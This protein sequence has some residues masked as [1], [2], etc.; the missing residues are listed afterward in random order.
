MNKTTSSRRK[1][2]FFARSMARAYQ[3]W[4]ERRTET[5]KKRGNRS[6][7]TRIKAEKRPLFAEALEPRVLFSGSPM[8]V[9]EPADSDQGGQ[10]A[11]A[12]SAAVLDDG[13]DAVSQFSFEG[14]ESED[15]DFSESD[16][17]RLAAEAIVRW[18][19]TGLSAGQLEALEQI[20]YVVTDLEGS[21]LAFAEGDSIYIDYNGAGAD[22][23]V[24]DT[25]WLDEEF[26]EI[27][28]ILRAI[29]GDDI[30]GLAGE[31]VDL[32]SVLMHE[33]GHI[34]GL[35]D[36]Y[37]SESE[38]SAMHGL[39]EEGERRVLAHAQA[40][41][42][43]P[44]APDL[45]H[46]AALKDGTGNWIGET[47]VG[48]NGDNWTTGANWSDGSAPTENPFP[49]VIFD[50]GNTNV[51][52][53]TGG[54]GGR[55]VNSIVFD[56]G[57]G[58]F[59]LSGN[60]IDLLGTSGVGDAAE[61]V[62]LSTNTQTINSQLILRPDLTSGTTINA[63]A[64]DIV[65]GG[66]IRQL[67][68]GNS[69]SITG[70]HIVT[71]SG[72]NTYSD[73]TLIGY[74]FVEDDFESY[75]VGVSGSDSVWNK[76]TT[77]RVA[78]AS[79]VDGNFLSFG[80]DGGL[81]SG[82][83]GGSTE[84]RGIHR[85]LEDASISVGSTG[86]VTFD[87]RTTDENGEWYYGLT[88]KI[89]GRVEDV[90]TAGAQPR[91]A[92]DMRAYVGLVSDGIVG[93]GKVNLVAAD[94]GTG[95]VTL[96]TGLNID[97][98]HQIELRIDHTANTYEVFLG[99]VQQGGTLNFAPATG[100]L[101]YF[102]AMGAG[103]SRT[104]TPFD[105]Q[106][107]NLQANA[108]TGSAT[109]L[110]NGTHTGAGSYAVG[111]ESTLGGT[112]SSDAEVSVFGTL[113]PGELS[114]IESL[115]VGGL[116][117]L[118]GSTFEVQIGG[119]GSMVA[120]SGND[121]VNVTGDVV[122]GSGVSTL[123]V[124]SLGTPATGA[125]AYTLI[126]IESGT[127]TGYFKDSSGTA[128]IEGATVTVGGIDY[129]ISYRGGDGNDVVLT[130][131]QVLYVNSDFVL[132]EIELDSENYAT[133]PA[134]TKAGEW[135]SS[136]TS[137]G[138][139]GNNYLAVANADTT[140]NTVEYAPELQGG[141]YD[142]SMRWVAASN[143][144]TN[145]T[146]TIVDGYGDSHVVSVN[147]EQNNNV[148]V[149]LGEY[150]FA[151]GNAGSVTISNE[152]ANEYVIAD[153]M[154]F[155][156]IL[157]VGSDAD[158]EVI[159]DQPGT[160]YNSIS[161][162]IAAAATDE[163]LTLI[164]NQ[165]DYSAEDIDLSSFTDT[166]TIKFIEGDSSIGS[167]TGGS[168]VTV[169]LGGIDGSHSVATTLSVGSGA[170]G[171]VI[172]GDGGLTKTGVGDFVLFGSLN[173][174]TGATQVL[175]GVLQVESGSI[176]ATDLILID[177]G[178]FQVINGGTVNVTN[179]VT[180]GAGAGSLLVDHG[181]MT[182][183]SG[184]DVDTLRTGLN[185]GTSQLTV[186]SGVV[187]V[188]NGTEDLHIGRTEVASNNT[189]GTVDFS[190]ASSV[191]ID[192][193]NLRLGTTLAAANPG[194]SRGSL[195]LS[196][197]GSN[198]V[199]ANSILIGDSPSA[200]NTS[201]PSTIVLGLDNIFNVD[202]FTIGGQKSHGRVTIAS[203][204]VFDLSGNVN[205]STDLNL[206]FNVTGNTG[207][208]S[209]GLLDL[210][211]GI[212]NATLDD[213]R[214]GRHDIGPGSG[215][216][217]ITFDAGTVTANTVALGTG[218]L[219]STGTINQRGGTFTV[220]N[221]VSE[222]R[223][224]TLNIEAGN[225]VV[226]AGGLEVDNLTVGYADLDDIGT[227][228]NTGILTVNGGA[229]SIGDGV[230]N[231]LRI[232]Y[233]TGAN[234]G[235]PIAIGGVNFTQADS[236]TINV[237][238]IFIGSL[239]AS[240][241]TGTRG[242]LELSNVGDNTITADRIIVGDS[243]SPGNQGVTSTLTFGSNMNTV[244]VDTFDV[245][246]RKS[247][248]TV[249]IVSGGTLDLSGNLNA[250]NETDLR[251]GINDSANTGT[252]TTGVFDM[253]NGVFNAT[254]D[255]IILGRHASSSGGPG[256]G[257]GTLTFDEGTVTARSVLL[258]DPAPTSTAPQNTDGILNLGG[259]ILNL[260]GGN[261]TEGGGTEKFNFTDGVLKD[262]NI[263][264]FSFTQQGGTLQI[265]ADD[266]A[267]STTIDGDFTATGGTLEFDIQGTAGAGVA[268]G[269]DTI[270]VDSTAG[271]GSVTLGGTLGLNVS[272]GNNLAPGTEIVLIDNDGAAD[273]VTGTFAG[274]AEGST[275]T[276]D[277]NSFI[278]SYAGGDGN[279]VT[280]TALND[281][282]V[283]NADTNFA[284]E[285]GGLNNADITVGGDGT[286]LSGTSGNVLG[287]TGATAGDV[288]DGDADTGDGTIS[289]DSVIPGE[290]VV[291][292]IDYTGGGTP[293]GAE[294]GGT[295]TGA[296]SVDG[297][298]GSLTINPDGS[299]SYVLD[300]A[301]ADTIAA[302]ESQTDEFTYTIS[303]FGQPG[304]MAGFVA[305]SNNTTDPN[306]GNLGTT[307][308]P[309]AFWASGGARDADREAAWGDPA[310]KT[311]V[312]TGQVYLEAGDTHFL[313]MS[314]D[315][316]YLAIDGSVII[317]EVGWNTG[318]AGTF[319]NSTG[320]AG[321]FDIEIR[322]GN[323]GG[324]YGFFNQSASGE[325]GWAGIESGFL[326][327]S[328]GAASS[329]PADPGWA[330]P[331]DPGPGTLF[332]SRIGTSTATLTMTVNGTNDVP[333][334]AVEAGDSA[335][336]NLAET[337][338][339]LIT[340]GTLSVIDLDT[341]DTV[342]AAVT[343]VVV[344]GD[345][346]GLGNAALLAMLTTGTNPVISNTATTADL[347]WTFDSGSEA[348]N[349]LAASETLV[350]EYTITVTDSQ[351]TTDTQTVTIT[352]R[353]VNDAPELAGVAI[354][355]ENEATKTT[356]SGTITDADFNGDGYTITVDWADVNDAGVKVYDLANLDA[357][358]G[359]YN[360]VTGAFA[361]FHT[362]ADD[363]PTATASDNLTVSVQ[364]WETLGYKL[365]ALYNFDHGDARDGTA[366]GNDGTIVD[367]GI[368][369]STGDAPAVLN[370]GGVANGEDSGYISVAHSASL[371]EIVDEL[372]VSFWIKADVADND[373][374]FRIIR[375]GNGS[376][377]SGN[378][379]WMINRTGD[380]DEVNLRTDTFPNDGV[381]GQHNRNQHFNSGS[382]VLDG[383]WHH[384]TYVLNSGDSR[385]YV[386]GV[387]NSS[388]TYL[389]GNGLANTDA[390]QLLGR[391]STDGIFGSMD[392]IALY[393]RALS[394]AE[395][396]QLASSPVPT[397]VSSQI[398]QVVTT[399]S[400]VAP[401]VSL[402]APAGISENDTATLS[403][404]IA[405]V[406]TLD[407][408]TLA[409]NWGDPASP[410]NT[411]TIALG[412]VALTKAIDG[413][414]WNPTTRVFAI[415]HQYLDDNPT[416]TASDSYTI[417][418]TVTD[419]DT[420][421]VME[422]TSVTVTN[423]D[424]VITVGGTDSVA[425][426][427]IEADATL[428]VSGTISVSDAG[429]LDT[430]LATINPAVTISGT[431][432][433]LTNADVLAMFSLS[434][435]TTGTVG[436]TFDSSSKPESF[437]FLG[438]GQSLTL[439]YT[440]T[441][442][443]DDTGT[444]TG[445][446]A[447]TITGTNDAPVANPDT[448]T[449]VEA[450]GLNNGT[451]AVGGDGTTVSGTSGNVMGGTGATAGDAADSD[452]DS[453]DDPVAGDGSVVVANVK[454][455][456]GGTALGT[457]AG[458]IVDGATQVDGQYGT[459]T[460]NPDGSYD[461]VLQ[462]DAS[463]VL[464]AGETGIEEFT[465]LISDGV[466][467]GDNFSGTGA[468][469]GAVPNSAPGAEAWTSSPLWNADGTKAVN[470][471]GS[472]WLPFSPEDGKIYTLSADVNP[473]LSTSADWLAL[474][475]GGLAPGDMDQAQFQ[476]GVN[477]GT[478]W[479]LFRENDGFGSVIQT[480]R[481]PGTALGQS[482]D[483]TPDVVGSAKLEVILDTTEANWTIE[484]KIDG[485][486][487]RSLAYTTNPTIQSVGI[488]G[489]NTATGAIDNFSLVEGG[490]DSTTLTIT[491]DGTN[492][493]PVITSAAQ[494]GAITETGDDTDP[495]PVT[496]TITFEDA[497]LIDTH[498]A[499]VL[500][501]A[502]VTG[503]TATL[504]AAQEAA[505]LDNLSLGTV[506][507]DTPGDGS[508]SVGWTYTVPNSEIDFL[509]AG[510]TVE[511]THTVAVSD[512]GVVFNGDFSANAADFD[513]FPGYI[514][515]P[516]NPSGITGW[517]HT[518]SVGINPI[519][520]GSSP[521]AN[522]GNNYT[523][524]AFIQRT[525]SISQT[526]SGLTVG[527]TYVLSFDY[528]ERA[529]G[530]S[531]T[532]SATIAGETFT[533]PN[534]SPV[535]GVNPY[536]Q[537]LLVFT[538][539]AT[540][541]VLTISASENG[542]DQTTLIDNVQID[543]TQ[544]V[545]VTLTGANDA[546][547]ITSPAQTGA[548]TESV[549][550]VSGTD[551][552]PAPATGTITF[553]D[554]DLT[555]THTA[556]IL[557][558]ASVTGGT[559]TLTAAQ[560]AA[561]LDN[562]SL[563]AVQNDTPADG[564]GAVD[565]T[566]TVPNSEIDFLAAGETV[567]VTHTV[568]ISD[569][570]VV[571]NGDFSAN[572][573][574][575]G[576]YPGYL[577][578][579]N[580]GSIAG[581]THTGRAG[582]NYSGAGGPGTPFSDNGDNSTPVAFIQR[583][584]SISQTVSGLV[585]GQTYALM[586]DYNERNAGPAGSTTVSATIAGATFTNPDNSPVGG[587]NPY[588]QA[589]LLFTA[590]ATSETLT[591][592][593]L[594]NGG[595]QTTLI[596]NVRIGVTQDVV[597]TI[598]GANDQPLVTVAATDVNEGA[599]T[600]LTGDF[601]DP[602][603]N[604]PH[605]ITISWDDPNSLPDSVFLLP[606][607]GEIDLSVQDTFISSGA[608]S[609]SVL[610]I[611]SLDK[612]TGEVEFTVAHR[613]LDDG[614]SGGHFADG[615]NCTPSDVA[616]ISVV[617]ND[618]TSAAAGTSSVYANMLL[619]EGDNLTGYWRFDTVRGALTDTSGNGHT[620]TPQ[621]D[622]TTGAASAE[623]AFGEAASLDGNADLFAT[624]ATAGELGFTGDFTASAWIY[625]APGGSSGDNT[626][627][628]TDTTGL[629]NGLHLVVRDGKLRF[630]F[631]SNDTGGSQTLN[632]GEWYH[633]AYRYTGATGEQALFVNGVLDNASTGK[634]AFTG[635]ANEVKIGRWRNS[636]A[637]SF[638]G[639]LD[640]VSVISRSL[641]NAEILALAEA[642]QTGSNY[643]TTTITVSNVAPVLTLGNASV[644]ENGTAVMSGT[645]TDPGLL[646]SYLA[647]VDWG[648][649]NNIADA[650]FDIGAVLTANA[651]AGTTS[652]N[653]A[654]GTVLMSS[655][656]D[657]VM[658][659]TSTQA[660]LDAGVINFTLSRQVLDDGLSATPFASGANGTTTDDFTVTMR[661]VDDDQPSLE[662][663][664]AGDPDLNGF[665][666]MEEAGG[667]AATTTDDQVRDA[668]GN[669][670][671]GT[672]TNGATV[673]GALVLDGVDD[674]L[675]IGT[676]GDLGLNGSFTATATINLSDLSGDQT[677]FGTNRSVA[678]QGL[679]LVVR[680]GKLH[681]GFHSNDTASSVLLS[682]GQD[683]QVTFRYDAVAR[684]QTIFLD[685][686]QIAQGINKN[687]FAGPATDVVLIGKWRDT[688]SNAFTGTIDDAAI[689]GRAMTN[690]EIAALHD[691]VTAPVEATATLTVNNVA[692]AITLDPVSGIDEAGIATITGSATDAG[693]LDSHQI[694][695]NW[696]D[697]ND[698][699]DSVFDLGAVQLVDTID[700]ATSANPQMEV[701]DTYTSTSGDGAVLTI[702]SVAPD[703]SFTFEVTG[704]Q[705]IDDDVSGT[706]SDDY[707][708]TVT[709]TDDDAGT[710]ADSGAITV[711]NLAPEPQPDFYT[712]TEADVLIIS[713]P[714][715]GVLGNDNDAANPNG[716]LTSPIHDPLRVKSIDSSATKGIVTM[717][718]DGTF[719][720]DPN[721]QFEYLGVGQTETD[722]FLYTVEDNDGGTRTETVTITVR[723]V[724]DAP[725][726]VE[727]VVTVFEGGQGGSET[728]TGNALANDSDVDQ[729]GTPED[730][731]LTVVSIKFEGTPFGGAT[732]AGGAVSSSGTLV[733]GLYGTLS[734]NSKGE[735]VYTV[736][737][738]LPTT[739]ALDTG[740]VG[741]ETFTYLVSDGNGGFAE[742][743]I[744]V[745]VVG[746]TGGKI[747]DFFGVGG[748]GILEGFRFAG[749]R[750]EAESGEGAP[751]LM[752]MPTY[753]GMAEPGSVITLTVMGPGGV[754][755]KGG[756]MTVVADL[757]GAW[758]AK[759]SGLEIGNT[760]YFVKVETAAPAWE[761]GVAGTFKV[762]FAPA[763][764]GSH[765]E[766]DVLTVDSVMG[767]RLSAAA[768]D[769][770]IDANAHPNGSNAD[771]RKANGMDAVFQ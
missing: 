626:I 64:G 45:T 450:G 424:P 70:S 528:N 432:G 619:A 116:T 701:G 326:M 35:F 107:D 40:D 617:V 426:T 449:A 345:D 491:I 500:P 134:V 62:N 41:G 173:N 593:S 544:K 273:A 275:V 411:Q 761:T 427:L 691:C 225:F 51:Q 106:L 685:G 718:P 404:T 308:G 698:A 476:G 471:T 714:A 278:I 512:A 314:D 536:R 408:F 8:P 223:T 245:G 679:H 642:T 188:G 493:T 475:F 585:V 367:A 643:A 753:S 588:R 34:L 429:T 395:V 382:S 93:D 648:D 582:L 558:G 103:G 22:W 256:S 201:T 484:W 92:S 374:W 386:D 333:V 18:E 262:V 121:V 391:N 397:N 168:N 6:G 303:D 331:E 489:F 468:L 39:F 438:E 533:D 185:G 289:P 2:W 562:L 139:L 82:T 221:G 97:E 720:Y 442:T 477:L 23:F 242:N 279:D 694:T 118:E 230:A 455:T 487:L 604:D 231:D 508:G 184:L 156:Q 757:S 166:V 31:G 542:G 157:G 630:G 724:N 282:P 114:G 170:F 198:Q 174:Y 686:V 603:L 95:L 687:A 443:D 522:N 60:S 84:Y 605:T 135:F 393:S 497:D 359:T 165:G 752:L 111:V 668:S 364:V 418:V 516:N 205:P 125:H 711:S 91:S 510:E 739:R 187:N 746:S 301:A 283:A 178:I 163:P 568:V 81:N 27:D 445:T 224:S 304:L 399:V 666:R 401:T 77:G 664:L 72:D 132:E 353:G 511:V 420:L 85:N 366:N 700:G 615:E 579:A 207:T 676:V 340:T 456:G 647:V 566:Y 154:K 128:L 709:I 368:T 567:E 552:D 402:T 728:V 338:A 638:N 747:G 422:S 762:F 378:A 32:L 284:T 264:G 350:L 17:E 771:W 756:S 109:L 483:L 280:L 381:S 440:I 707:T 715:A 651:A 190:G 479:M 189:G 760:A 417:G 315:T 646:D 504:T 260:Q 105:G 99:G 681:F 498:T 534:N 708:V 509:A 28:G 124:T 271:D 1:R 257:D 725:V 444:D 160:I 226:T 770:I 164:V 731:V 104:S 30:D 47:W 768:L 71:F 631:F 177:D 627:F 702:K 218:A 142:V 80:Y 600:V 290:V 462:P 507:D 228:T 384:V 430:T 580:P 613:Y 689:I 133:D 291:S 532:V 325:P 197:N 554:V 153:G 263:I 596:D 277:G 578:G 765:T 749:G 235:V 688:S 403:G 344:T 704:H 143:R 538:A 412:N 656:D 767:R 9:E 307:S 623:T 629:N 754:T 196:T 215:A 159:G 529:S 721:G 21:A 506:Q 126:N 766:T 505:L 206:G 527:E 229:V 480:F 495:A 726:A 247:R 377:T 251:V 653:L 329:D 486:T 387:L 610:T 232:G 336:E 19:E 79:D 499:V 710:G 244:N 682:T 295:V 182:V 200:G 123:E 414:D 309:D 543:V 112:G 470:G 239:L 425:E 240:G 406:G 145:A 265:G 305:G 481:G 89:S 738:N 699:T 233:N 98:W 473:D 745:R 253:S 181:T 601:T 347:N 571:V 545:V 474:G 517:T 317:N 266:T 565:W 237:D 29:S 33:Q 361:L 541:E 482:H 713:T 763:I 392:D 141:I 324:G 337:D 394:A 259:G 42:V 436:W 660:E 48:G 5:G 390:L 625:I 556:K 602:D 703:G 149:S 734:I 569:S 478:A 584:G 748:S 712:T 594:T 530:G 55:N 732:H 306:P 183:G 113:A 606:K 549:D 57:A 316:S 742:E 195:T 148:Y 127:S 457:N 595:D 318:D 300:E 655:T 193:A 274:L 737:G 574:D 172:T 587:S 313:M 219:N 299:Y 744:V 590:S 576:T 54:S 4:L 683:Y 678:S 360:D 294:A 13:L 675:A 423:V 162:A 521:F 180:N 12:H 446:V 49:T 695:V 662:S 465:Y 250:N 191:T 68:S 581:W 537:A 285:A 736:D 741:V 212:F 518:G 86:V 769:A 362:Y 268:G 90:G 61:I 65:L 564:S 645:I 735:F 202:T 16:L 346:N 119:D 472:A 365:E 270:F 351:N 730:D 654:P 641:S 327:K 254:L 467:Y 677:V 573:A 634:S 559:A 115:D 130:F 234:T 38:G 379:T 75:A 358:D 494:T 169:E 332:R 213:V 733:N 727:D 293:V 248:G 461:Y 44:H 575:F 152:G 66:V 531:T 56:T 74:G 222:S 209:T 241:G 341:S 147:Q 515:N 671:H 485:T 514:S 186:T 302:G 175:E 674:Y 355:S 343:S 684:T 439:T 167:L 348:F 334:I 705:Y 150:Y 321:W 650:T 87:A 621:G 151:P 83:V 435:A 370:G 469:D 389:H 535:G 421:A 171:G 611:T 458:G 659:I 673:N 548:V 383:N 208:V 670:G 513:T 551:P 37:G 3:D 561:L 716:P 572:A 335:A 463:G 369:Y 496:G 269:H 352:I 312:Y 296:T 203:G 88:E 356:L 43:E 371:G 78:V 375:K 96:A 652:N 129:S 26:V 400:D 428:S 176:S 624:G 616:N 252:V 492:D 525:G 146:V 210:S 640:E 546:P 53:P 632:E 592:S 311:I 63:A 550:N 405:D 524:V 258:A 255:E 460:I 618:P 376:S 161:G 192:V 227:G 448:N 680:N 398:V 342:T 69:I 287:H 416:D 288:A 751:L 519:S 409:L 490:V 372:T 539:T 437:D 540:S 503:G 690:A 110:L 672:L 36:D 658:T 706:A 363:A 7:L 502:S 214:L 557:P 15:L 323:G 722:T 117:F 310:N 441:V 636:D 750:G 58:A 46:F 620:L 25:E 755:L 697:P 431:S 373:D 637:H 419:D 320:A 415:D 243:P 410:D 76:N 547:A 276:A 598:T 101:D 199:D 612:D 155:V 131:G 328:G 144:A 447:I 385:E 696:G 413:I 396:A 555:N 108:Y 589:V 349:Y 220:A 657:S 24:D 297:Q 138:Y 669:D 740:E 758:I 639:N 466:I 607:T 140:D 281:A 614:I 501:G 137:P 73:P 553:D 633:V 339:G 322:T 216:G 723:G 330:H 560:E 136:M 380:T 434:N 609:V 100:D 10:E 635:A 357:A 523:P 597:V 591:I 102:I 238:D 663:L 20:N 464:A 644:S 217:T 586:F 236:V 52:V 158:D 204:G 120:G 717:N 267:D 388:Q 628:G 563:G 649:P 622:A 298:Y 764:N 50:G 692:P 407:T 665:W 179:G 661:L 577:G 488:G 272:P 719:S 459:L 11:T 451:V 319:T 526:I 354:S 246:V 759:F 452:I 433:T 286:T 94:A 453:N 14:F 599:S 59:T 583:D 122:L 454:Y 729:S 194:T 743:Q 693:K 608:D 667:T 261:I 520:G 249:S 570:E 67:G 292:H 211:G